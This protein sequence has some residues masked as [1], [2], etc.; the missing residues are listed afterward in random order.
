MGYSICLVL[1]GL[2]AVVQF[3][4]LESS[5]LSWRNARRHRYSLDDLQ[6]A[7]GLERRS[8]LEAIVGAPGSDWLY[9]VPPEVWTRLPREKWW[10]RAADWLFAPTI[11][12]ALAS[13]ALTVYFGE[14]QWVPSGVTLG[15]FTLEI[16]GATYYVASREFEDHDD[17][18]ELW[19]D[20]ELDN[21]GIL[22]GCRHLCEGLD[23]ELENGEIRARRNEDH[24]GRTWFER[25]LLAAMDGY[26]YRKLR[27][28]RVQVAHML[29]TSEAIRQDL[30]IHR[31]AARGC[32]AE[33]DDPS[34][35]A[36]LC[37][38]E[39]NADSG[40]A[41]MEGRANPPAS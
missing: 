10:W 15:M 1:M 7:T 16:A 6:F 29:E 26:F 25:T 19:D 36:F 35:A 40:L 23:L 28:F 14:A 30:W 13:I 4:C 17:E 5:L 22:A 9:S 12:F 41:D 37:E 34:F 38:M 39:L 18:A 24:A 3:I 27:G 32:L 31:E 21:Q 33:T 20:E 2:V 8:E 11:L